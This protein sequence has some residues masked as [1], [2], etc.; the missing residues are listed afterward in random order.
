MKSLIALLLFILSSYGRLLHANDSAELANGSFDGFQSDGIAS[1]WSDNSGWADVTVKYSAER[2]EAHSNQSQKIDCVDFKSGAVQFVQSGVKISKGQNYTISI[3]MKGDVDSPVQILARRRGNPYTTYFSKSFKV[4]NTWRKYDFNVIAAGDDPDAYF[5]VSFASAGTLWLDDVTMTAGGARRSSALPLVGNLITNGSFEVGLDRWGINIREAGGYEYEMP[6]E[7]SKQQ[8][9]VDVNNAKIGRASLKIIIPKHGRA[10]LTSPYVKV[11]AGRKYSLSLWAAADKRRQVRIGVGAGNFGQSRSLA[12]TVQVGRVWKRYTFSAVLPS[13][14]GDAYYVFLESIG[15]GVIWVDGVQLEEGDPTQYVSH[16]LAEIGLKREGVATLYEVG[17]DA[18]LAAAV[19]S[20]KGGNFHVSIRSVSYE[21]TTSF[22]WQGDVAL[23]PNESHEVNFR[24]PAAHPGYYKLIADVSEAGKV[25]DSSEMAIGFVAKRSGMSTLDSP[26]GGHAQFSPESLNKMKMLG[27]G[28]LRMH[29]PLGTKWFVVEKDK[30]KFVFQDQPIR[31]AKSMGFNILGSLDTTPRWASTAP[32][33]QSGQGMGSY[34]SYPPRNLSDWE[35]YVYRT[36]SHYKGIIDYW[37]VWNEP[38]SGGFLK[39]AGLMGEFNKPAV[40]AELLKTAYIAAKR[41]NPNAVIVGGVGT[42]QPPTAWVKSIFKHDAYRYMDVLSFHFY[43]DGRPG[44]ALD[45]PTGVFV[46]QIRSLM[47]NYGNG[48][49]K[50]IW[51][52]ESGIMHPSTN[53]QNILEVSPGYSMSAADSVAYL[54]RNYAYLLASGVSKW[55][56]YS[57]FTS[58]Q[59]DRN[60]ATGFFEWD[61]SPRPMAL[62]YANLV[63]MID[64]KQYSRTLEFGKD[65]LGEE[66]KNAGGVVDILWVKGWKKNRASLT[67]PAPPSYASAVAYDAMGNVIGRATAL[68]EISLIV[69]KS[70]VYVV[71]LK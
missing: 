11:N 68:N 20:E 59:I 1:G 63:N 32:P 55:F 22:L 36:V 35:D 15:D 29:P 18:P 60:D 23:A 27:V 26:F 13:S 70:P 53:Y 54:I 5:M 50:P 67:L 21:G 46:G 45:T 7:A 8:P 64:G 19:S 2:A 25:L 30:G 6:V 37:E 47:R 65:I 24:C 66:F 38:D 69:T 9:V 3:W 43:T 17:K 44:D 49:E 14:P 52:S 57:M 58:H 16:G 10:L 12:E 41:A 42:G 61:G 71:Y 31:L 39:V 51:E 33:D 28:W 62:A 56:Y 34:R 40:Y 4:D 48:K